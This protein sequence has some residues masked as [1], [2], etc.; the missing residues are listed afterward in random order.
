MTPRDGG[1]KSHSPKQVGGSTSMKATCKKTQK[2]RKV[3]NKT[4][5]ELLINNLRAKPRQCGQK[6]IG[7]QPSP[8][9]C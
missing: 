2:P 1:E 5:T 6:I 3:M 9:I 4:E 7:L 8:Y